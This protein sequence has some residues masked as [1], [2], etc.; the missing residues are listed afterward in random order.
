M[1]I[2]TVTKR[3]TKVTETKTQVYSKIPRPGELSIAGAEKRFKDVKYQNT[4]YIPQYN[5]VGEKEDIISYLR[6]TLSTTVTRKKKPLTENEI[7]KE[8]ET[9]L[10]V[11][12][13]KYNLE[14]NPEILAK[15][16]KEVEETNPRKKNALPL[17]DKKTYKIDDLKSISKWLDETGKPSKRTNKHP[18]HVELKKELS[19]R[20]NS[21]KDEQ[22]LDVSRCIDD[23]ID[24]RTVTLKDVKDYFKHP[25]RS[26]YSSSQDVLDTVSY[27]VTNKNEN[28]KS[29]RIGRKVESS[30]HVKK[31]KNKVSNENKPTLDVTE[32]N[33]ANSKPEVS[34]IK[35]PKK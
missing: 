5:V 28:K 22:V 10:S 25:T 7:N 34:R 16:K 24:I 20:L 31:P 33:E 3:K 30:V 6:K 1:V 15:Y 17:R 18:K 12:Y 19:E 29:N 13:S 4:F 2:S 8:I 21:L 35:S 27:S 9:I 11:S 14:N 23:V 26:V 32:N